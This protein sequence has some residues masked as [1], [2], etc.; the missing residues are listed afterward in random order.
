M[1]DTRPQ[2]WLRGVLEPI[3]LSIVSGGPSYGYAI[4]S[5]IADAGL[6]VVKGGTLYPLL[7]R[8][9]REGL[10]VSEWRQGDG[11]PGRKFYELSTAGHERLA[12]QR[13]QWRQFASSAS[14][15]IIGQEGQA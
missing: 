4:A 11:G 9:E 6:G 7:N 8:L 3:V 10:L 12:T 5:G 14:S 2:D 13:E 15:V 1:N